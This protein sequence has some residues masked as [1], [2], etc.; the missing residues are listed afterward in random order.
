MLTKKAPILIHEVDVSPYDKGYNVKAPLIGPGHQAINWH[1]VSPWNC[2]LNR[3]RITVITM[4]Q[5]YTLESK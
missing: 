4:G 5:A 1:G 3:V 2:T